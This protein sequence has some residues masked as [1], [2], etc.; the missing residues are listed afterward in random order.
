[1]GILRR[2]AAVLVRIDPGLWYVI[3]LRRR[4]ALSW[5]PVALML[6]PFA[7]GAVQCYLAAN[8]AGGMTLS[9]LALTLLFAKLRASVHGKVVGRHT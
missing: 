1:M 6:A 8:S 2:V 5:V 4:S 9:A 7:F 3:D